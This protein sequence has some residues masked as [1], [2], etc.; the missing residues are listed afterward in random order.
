MLA[1]EGKTVVQDDGA[2]RLGNQSDPGGGLVETLK[3][4]DLR[5]TSL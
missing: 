5:L 2:E 3:I 4:G 1:T